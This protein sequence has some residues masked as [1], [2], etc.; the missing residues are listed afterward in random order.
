MMLPGRPALTMRRAAHW[1][2]RQTPSRL[3]ESMARQSSSLI[4]SARRPL[5]IPALLTTTSTTP[6]AASAASKA[7]S[8]LSRLVTSIATSSTLAPLS[9]SSAAS[10]CRRSTRRAPITTRAPAAVTVWAK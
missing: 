2:T 7:A 3:V 8:T 10:T 1:A 4:S 6:N 9:R 5:P